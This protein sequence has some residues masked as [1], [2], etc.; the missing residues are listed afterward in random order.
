MGHGVIGDL[1]A[2][3]RH[4][5]N[6]AVVTRILEIISHHEKRRSN[7]IRLQEMVQL[8]QSHLKF[9]IGVATRAAASVSLVYGCQGI[10]VDGY[11]SPKNSVQISTWFLSSPQLYKTSTSKGRGRQVAVPVAPSKYRADAMWIAT[12]GRP[13]SIQR[14]G[15]RNKKINKQ[16]L[17]IITQP[18]TAHDG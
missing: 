2:G 3:C 16:F 12:N 9:R 15:R 8:L 5:G 6:N 1:V 13:N 11:G 7:L 18:D 14:I 10:Y 17:N 4:G